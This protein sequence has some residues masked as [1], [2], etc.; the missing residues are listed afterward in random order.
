MSTT[1][2]PDIPERSWTNPFAE[3]TPLWELFGEVV[4]QERDIVIVLDDYL[5]RRGTG[6]TVAS[7]QIASGMDQ[8]DAG[9]TTDKTALD[10]EEIRNAYSTQPKRSGLVLDEGEVGASNRDAMTNSNKALREIMSMGRVEQKYVVI[11]APTKSFI[12]KDLLRL[13]DVWITMVRR[14]L[15][16]VHFLEHEPYSGNLLTPQVQWLEI[17]DIPRGTDLRAVYNNLT[18]EKR[19]R[20]DGGDGGS[21]LTGEEHE[22]ELSKARK[23]ARKDVRNEL[24]KGILNHPEIQASG[25]SQRMIGEAVGV[26]QGTI[27]NIKSGE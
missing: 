25:I 18:E 6:K 27:S 13:A 4:R 17:T 26:S 19:D 12:D 7:L 2:S 20:I 11:N 24:V 9:M 14:G 1:E 8:T 3:E 16:L 15:G 22:E 23:E 21:Y 10:P 5:A